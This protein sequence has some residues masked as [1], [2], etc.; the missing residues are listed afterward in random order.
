MKEANRSSSLPKWLGNH[1]EHRC[2]SYPDPLFDITAGS[3]SGLARGSHKPHL[4][5]EDIGSNPI[6]AN[7]Y[8]GL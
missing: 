3:S 5:T 6:P 1:D 8:K 7:F 2:K 4:L